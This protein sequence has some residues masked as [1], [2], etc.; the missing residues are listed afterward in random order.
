MI[1]IRAMGGDTEMNAPMLS[2]ITRRFADRSIPKAFSF[3]FFCDGCGKEWRSTPQAFHSN[4]LKSLTDLRIVRML[5]N[6]RHK[7]AYEQANLEAIY[8]FFYCPKCRRRLCME[9]FRRSETDAAD[10]CKDCLKK[11]ENARCL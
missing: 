6:G 10:I 11:R 3:S 9:C 1:A 4:G 7:A 8:A 2:P 5:W